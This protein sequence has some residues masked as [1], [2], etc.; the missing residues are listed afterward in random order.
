MGAFSL[1]IFVVMHPLNGIFVRH[2]AF[3]AFTSP[4]FLTLAAAL[5]L[6]CMIAYRLSASLWPP[7]LMHWI[8]VVIWTLF[9]GGKRLLTGS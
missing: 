4:V 9:L 8:T 5:G 6:C 1:A 7:I 2:E 3:V